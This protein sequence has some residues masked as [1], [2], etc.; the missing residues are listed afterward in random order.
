MEHLANHDGNFSEVQVRAIGEAG[1][2]SPSYLRA[3]D[4]PFCTEWAKA[5]S[6]KTS[7]PSDTR[8]ETELSPKVSLKRFKVYVASHLEQLAIF[9][10]PRSLY[11]EGS[12]PSGSVDSDSLR[13]RMEDLGD[14]DDAVYSDSDLSS[15]FYKE[16]HYGH[17]DA[18]GSREVA[19]CHACS[20]EWYRD[21]HGTTCPKCR[22]DIVEIV[23]SP[24]GLS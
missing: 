1:K 19:F 4:C 21:E 15:R 10:I 17:L 24:L 3:A 12:A 13:L 20:H 7:S 2:E 23:C 18:T 5:L 16:A 11:P 8:A 22:G 14:D 9:A 6:K